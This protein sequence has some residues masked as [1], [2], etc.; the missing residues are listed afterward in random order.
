MAYF[1]EIYHLPLFSRAFLFAERPP[2]IGIISELL[3]TV[4]LLQTLTRFF[5]EFFGCGILLGAITG[6]CPPSF[7]LPSRCFFI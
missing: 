1:L 5:A 3:E 2:A 6:A 4:N 7:L